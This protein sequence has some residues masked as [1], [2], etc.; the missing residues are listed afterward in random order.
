MKARSLHAKKRIDILEF[1]NTLYDAIES[2]MNDFVD[3]YRRKTGG[4]R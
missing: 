3:Q 1:G 4:R 2:E